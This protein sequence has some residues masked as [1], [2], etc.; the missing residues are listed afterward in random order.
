MRTSIRTLFVLII[1]SLIPLTAVQAG[2]DALYAAEAPDGAAFVRVVNAN[3]SGNITEAR[4]GGKVIKEIEPLEVSA[5]I[6]LPAGS[7]QLEVSGQS[8]PIS[9]TK[10]KFYTAVLLDSGEL[11]ILA[12]ADFNNPRKALVSFYNLTS[13]GAVALK[14]ADGKVAVVDSVAPLAVANREINAVKV[15]L[16]AFSSGQALAKTG[17]VNLQRGK[18]FS[19]F[20]IDVGGT[21]RLVVTENRVDTSV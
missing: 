3:T 10:N 12:D 8:K 19:F 2:E 6:Y 5:Y 14:T 4:V 1:S 18:V 7:Y 21:P 17:R 15:A 16:G 13:G 9:M 11:K 20:A